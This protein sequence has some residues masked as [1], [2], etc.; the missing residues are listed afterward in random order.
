MDKRTDLRVQRT[1]KLIKETTKEMICEMPPEK[2]TVTELTKRAG[3]HRKTFYLHYVSIE[4]LFMELLQE[5][6]DG[7]YQEIDQVPPPMPMEERNRVF[8][9][10]WA[11]QEQFAEILICQKSYRSFSDQIFE[12]TMKHNRSR[13]NP[14]ADLP[15]EEQKL[16]NTFTGESSLALYRCWVENGKQIPLE[17]V[18]ELAGKLVSYGVENVMEY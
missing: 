18:T 15:A 14:Y 5:V 13:F 1:L 12:M 7:Y 8:F 6:V 3:I 10:Y 16:V 17:R 11:N 2:I 9:H 4:E